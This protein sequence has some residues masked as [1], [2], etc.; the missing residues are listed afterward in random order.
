MIVKDETGN[1]R[2]RA[3]ESE[4]ERER[5]MCGKRKWMDEELLTKNA[6]KE[7][8]RKAVEARKVALG[9]RRA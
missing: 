9:W 7:S 3:R 2:E 5:E 6:R 8:P 4:T 1:R